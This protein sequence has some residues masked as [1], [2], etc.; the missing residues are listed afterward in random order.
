MK[1]TFKR[2]KMKN[3]NLN[4]RINYFFRFRFKYHPID[5]NVFKEDHKG[6]IQKRLNIFNSLMENERINSKSLD[7]TNA[8]NIIRLMD[9]VVI[10]LEDGSDEAVEEMYNEKID[11]ESLTY[12]EKL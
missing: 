1:N 2:T 7:Y 5:S 6:C 3:G 4:L 9:T 10:K 8:E 11:D 12:L